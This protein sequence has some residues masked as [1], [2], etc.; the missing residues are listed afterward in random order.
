MFTVPF[1][2]KEERRIDNISNFGDWSDSDSSG[3]NKNRCKSQNQIVTM[4]KIFKQPPN[5]KISY[6]RFNAFDLNEL[7]SNSEIISTPS[8]KLESSVFQFNLTNL[9]MPPLTQPQDDGDDVKRVGSFNFFPSQFA[10]DEEQALSADGGEDNHFFQYPKARRQV[11]DLSQISEGLFRS[12]S[13]QVVCQ[14]SIKNEGTEQCYYPFGFSPEFDKDSSDLNGEE[15]QVKFTSYEEDL[16]KAG[17]SSARNEEMPPKIDLSQGDKDHQESNNMVKAK[18]KKLADQDNIKPV[19]DLS[20]QEEL[21][22]TKNCKAT[23][24]KTKAKMK[25]SKA[26]LKDLKFMQKVKESKFGH[27]SRGDS[28]EIALKSRLSRSH[29]CQRPSTKL[30]SSFSR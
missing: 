16:S 4:K 7:T 23:T 10:Q 22:E 30:S 15:Y 5:I 19:R 1:S 20:L 2:S 28:P 3:R 21:K 27:V 8:F 11:S 13:Q 24:R 18:C 29:I 17:D 25:S 26:V 12:E 9:I 6:S 14:N